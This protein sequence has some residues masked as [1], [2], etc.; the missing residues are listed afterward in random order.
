MLKILPKSFI[1]TRANIRDL[2][3]LLIEQEGKIIY[4]LV[5]K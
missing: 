2:I 3:R 5:T 1:S 4:V